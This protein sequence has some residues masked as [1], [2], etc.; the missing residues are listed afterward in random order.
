MKRR[1]LPLLGGAITTARALRT[2]Q[3]LM[4]VIGILGAALPEAKQVQLNL[5]AFRQ[6]LGEFG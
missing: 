3:K 6:G 4:P 5:A 1:E 2:Q